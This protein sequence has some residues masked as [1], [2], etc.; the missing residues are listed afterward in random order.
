MA[1][2]RRN[3]GRRCSPALFSRPHRGLLRHAGGAGQTFL[4]FDKK[5]GNLAWKSGDE[6]ITEIEGVGPVTFTQAAGFLK[7]PG[8][9]HPLDRTWVHPES[10]EVARRIAKTLTSNEI[11]VIPPLEPGKKLQS[12]PTT[13]EGGHHAKAL[14]RDI[15]PG[16]SKATSEARLRHAG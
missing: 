14:R 11:T 12:Q 9:A 5:T 8:G 10:Y 15:W 6:K 7:I 4:A 13:G 1:R 16:R 2:R 3:P